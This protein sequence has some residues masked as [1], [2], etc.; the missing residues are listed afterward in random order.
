M[1]AFNAASMVVMLE[2]SIFLIVLGLAL[3]FIHRHKRNR[4]LH[5][6]HEFIDKLERHAL[7]KNQPL[8][9]LLADNYGVDSQTITDAVKNIQDAERT[10]LQTVI[11]FFLQRELGVL[12]K[13]EQ[14]LTKLSASYH[15]LLEDLTLG[16]SGSA[17]ANASEDSGKYGQ[18]EHANQQLMRQLDTAMKTID[19]ITAEYSRAFSGHQ[20]GLELENSGKK[21]LQIFQEAQRDIKCQMEP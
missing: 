14:D 7:L 3:F 16:E 5:S 9:E 1:T 17:V 10:L 19:E 20:T 4:E 2:I 21:L 12:P 15:Q 18:L 11:Q 6:L 8:E 13:I